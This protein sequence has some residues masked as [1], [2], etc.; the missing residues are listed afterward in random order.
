VQLAHESGELESLNV[1]VIDEQ[2]VTKM[3]LEN[4]WKQKVAWK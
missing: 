3:H 2:V 4:L 1:V